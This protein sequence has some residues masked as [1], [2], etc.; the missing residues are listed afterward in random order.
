MIKNKKNMLHHKNP[1]VHKRRLNPHKLILVILLILTPFLS[2]IRPASGATRYVPTQYANIQAAVDAALSGDIIQVAA[3]TYYEHV[4]INKTLQIIG[5]NPTTTIV[6]GTQNGTAFYIEDA[7]NVLIKGF[8]IRNSGNDNSAVVSTR[9]IVGTDNNRIEGN[10]I[11]TSQYGIQFSASDGNKIYNNTI[12]DNP[13]GDIYLN[14]ADSANVTGNIITNSAYGIKVSSSLNN[15]IQIN[16]ITQT[17]YGIYLVS[18]STGN[19]IKRNTITGRTV[20]IYSS[21]DTTTIDHNTITESA[22]G[23]YLYNS[24][25]STINYNTLTN[26]S[27]GVR[28]YWSSLTASSHVIT[29]NKVTGSDWALELVNSNSNTFRGNWLEGNTYGIYLTTSGSNVIYRNNFINNGM[30]AFSGTMPNTWDSAGNGNRWSDYTGGD[31]NGNGIGDTAYV[32]V[33]MGQDNYPL[34]R[35]WSEH[36]IAVQSVTPSATEVNP[37]ATVTITVTVRNNA[38]ISTSETFT[39][40]TKYN[41]T[42]ISTQQ[43]TA[44]TQGSTRILT[45]NWNTT[46]VQAGNYTIK[47]EASVVTDELNT[48]NNKLTDGT[49]KIKA[50]LTGDINGDGTINDQDLNL[51]TQAYGSAPGDP[52]WNPNADLDKNNKINITDLN[53]LGQDY[54]KTN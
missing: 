29:N 20:G 42:I 11:T 54:G 13:F 21:S 35:T 8:T 23:I 45:F 49:V 44:L 2:Q 6:D 39:V 25:T 14:N 1:R 4:F 41:N 19:Q 31:A 38:N 16:I 26:N 48:S 12:V 5:A 50:P 18:A 51:L 43:V 27:Y 28:L 36:D 46:G 24:K 34:M 3:G 53:I 7:K 15:I 47:A 17:S 52:N 40:T 10:I 37:G 22:Y 30:Q 32:I 33:P 9:E